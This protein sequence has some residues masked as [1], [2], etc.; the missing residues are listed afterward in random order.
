VEEPVEKESSWGRI[1]LGLGVL[2]LALWGLSWGLIWWQPGTL[3]AGPFGDM[4]SAVNA[5]FSGL[6][7]AGVIVAILMQHDELRLQRKELARS[8]KAQEA[9]ERVLVIAAQL[10]ANTVL[11]QHSREMVSTGAGIPV[12][13]NRR[14]GQSDAVEIYVNGRL[15]EITLLLDKLG[16]SIEVR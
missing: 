5:L 4:F 2:I 16:D 1:A 11:L 10:N 12:D 8:A 6:A 9:Q 7:F 3:G 15:A 13:F 14:F